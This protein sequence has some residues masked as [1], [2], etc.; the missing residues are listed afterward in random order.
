MTVER[1]ARLARVMRLGAAAVLLTVAPVL[2]ATNL[3]VRVRSGGQASVQ[4]AP[5]ASVPWEI[6]GVLSD[7]ASDGWPNETS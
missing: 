2:R 5:G 4:V 6:V 7:A 3:D 1:R